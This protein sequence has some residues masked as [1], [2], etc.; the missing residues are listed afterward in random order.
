LTSCMRQ[1]S[2]AGRGAPFMTEQKN[3]QRLAV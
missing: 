3:W 1:R 2:I